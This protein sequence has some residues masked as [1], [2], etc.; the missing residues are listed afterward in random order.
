MEE[1][2]SSLLIPRI[3]TLLRQMHVVSALQLH[4]KLTVGPSGELSAAPPSALTALQRT[5]GGESRLAGIEAVGSVVTEL[6]ALVRTECDRYRRGAEGIKVVVASWVEALCC[7]VAGLNTLA[8]TYHGDHGFASR[9]TAVI[10]QID[11]LRLVANETVGLDVALCPSPAL[12]ENRLI[13]SAA[14]RGECA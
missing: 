3:E 8:R 2:A 1:G 11:A 10:R 14:G 6:D 12:R 7:S 5:W 9:V 13:E 4:E